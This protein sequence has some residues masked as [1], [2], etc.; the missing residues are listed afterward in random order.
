MGPQT[1]QS[2]VQISADA[3]DLVLLKMYKLVLGHEA[4]HSP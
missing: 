2:G 3:R 1:V 4:D